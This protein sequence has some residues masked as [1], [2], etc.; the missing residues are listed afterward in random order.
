MADVIKCF[1]VKEFL[2]AE[3]ERSM[4]LYDLAYHCWQFG[5]KRAKCMELAQQIDS[6]ITEAEWAK[7]F[8]QMFD[9]Q[10]SGY[11]DATE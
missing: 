5:F 1:K 3:A 9:E 2:A 10:L 11:T 6:N 8:K 4:K 7:V